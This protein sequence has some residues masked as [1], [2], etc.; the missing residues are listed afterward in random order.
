MTIL[1]V[2]PRP[3]SGK[4]FPPKLALNRAYFDGL[5][6]AGATALPIP[7]VRSERYFR[8]LCKMLDGLLLRRGAD[9]EPRRYGES[10]REDA[11]LNVMPELMKYS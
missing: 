11:H 3:F 9:V 5:E 8:A 2:T 7:V 1:G 6:A 4:G 10:P